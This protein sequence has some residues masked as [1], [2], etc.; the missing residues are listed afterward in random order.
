MTTDSLVLILA[1]VVITAI[2]LWRVV[3]PIIKAFRKG[4]REG[5]R[6]KTVSTKRV[7]D[8]RPSVSKA[9]E[10]KNE[11]PGKRTTPT[12][13]IGTNNIFVSY[14]RADSADVAGRIYDRLIARFG[15]SEVFKDVDS[16]PLGVDFK[17]YLDNIVSRCKVLLVVIGDKW[18]GATDSTGQI[19]L[20]DPRDFVRIEIEAA[21]MRDIPV[22]PLLVQG[23]SMPPEEKL[24]P[25]LRKLI[26]R[27]GIPI[28]PD[29]DFHRD[30]DRLIA[31]IEL[32]IKR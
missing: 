1:I 3:I 8:S 31:A 13:K 28:R 26:F 27:N 29:P 7:Q 9:P 12:P 24:P 18:L 2:V 32:H 4:Y 23:A 14:R 19:R 25:G 6:K 11:Q 16:I 15:Q 20:N 30:M 22:I 10:I 17:E 5:S 21:L